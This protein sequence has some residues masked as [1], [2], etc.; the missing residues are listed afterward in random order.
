[1]DS[2][3]SVS[4]NRKSRGSPRRIGFILSLSRGQ[5]PDCC[6]GIEEGIHHSSRQTINIILLEFKN[7]ICLFGLLPDEEVGVPSN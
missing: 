2:D 5:N 1:V 3:T 6:L 7:S 4:D